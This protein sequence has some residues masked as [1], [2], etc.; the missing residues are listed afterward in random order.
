MS[1]N[2]YYVNTY[3]PT[4]SAALVEDFLNFID[5]EAHRRFFG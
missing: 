1:D 5:A 3:Q 4:V 2:V